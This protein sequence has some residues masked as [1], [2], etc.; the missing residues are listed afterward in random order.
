MLELRSGTLIDLAVVIAFGI[1][2]AR[3]G[4]R[5][6]RP[7]WSRN[8]WLAFGL[9]VLAGIALVGL[10]F[11]LTSAITGHAS[12]VGASGS[13]IRAAVILATLGSLVGGTLVTGLSLAWFAQGDA[14][15]PF[16]FVASSRDDSF[17]SL[18]SG[19]TLAPAELNARGSID[20][21]RPRR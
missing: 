16:P 11:V 17:D 19:A 3:R 18:R 15:R 12:W 8:S 20:A 13:N 1:A 21:P 2:A 4:Y 6:R 9:T 5:H 7:H 14:E 10:S